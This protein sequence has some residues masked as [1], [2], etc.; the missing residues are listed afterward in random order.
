MS[1]TLGSWE[2]RVIASMCQ[3]KVAGLTFN[4]AWRRATLDVPIPRTCHAS[5]PAQLFL[6]AGDDPE[7]IGV[8]DAM[9]GYAEDAWFGRKPGLR[10]F[11]LDILRDSDHSSAAHRARH[12]WVAA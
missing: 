7:E 9:R 2:Q 5:T 4:A 12:I 8:V 6:V 11:S 1:R 10:H 3:S